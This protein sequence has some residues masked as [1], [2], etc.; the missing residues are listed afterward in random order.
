MALEFCEPTDELR[1]MANKLI[2]D[3]FTHLS[4]KRVE[5]VFVQDV[6]KEGNVTAPSSKG[7][8]IWGRASV[9]SGKNAY[10]AIPQIDRPTVAEPA[11]AEKFFLI[12]I[13]KPIWE[14]LENKP[15]EREALL[16][17][18]LMH[19]ELDERGNPTIRHHDVEEFNATVRRYG[20][21]KDDVQLF[22][23]ASVEQM[24]L[25]KLMGMQSANDSEL[26]DVI[27]VEHEGRKLRINRMDLMTW[28][29][30]IDARHDLLRDSAQAREFAQ[31]VKKRLASSMH[32]ITGVDSVT[33]ITP[34]GREYEV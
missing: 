4:T 8:A 30:Q 18:E 14:S 5:F 31:K 13:A 22:L 29:Q 20:L 15:R 33:I 25:L 10:L 19:C 32:N 11:E 17:H 3:H 34:S 6:D 9:I 24:P 21:W 28:W 16:H 1:R 7:K 27:E 2:N 26:F 12:E 23:E